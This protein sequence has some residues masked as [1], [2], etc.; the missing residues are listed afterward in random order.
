[1]SNL[2]TDVF[3]PIGII[4]KNPTMKKYAKNWISSTKIYLLVNDASK[5]I[6]KLYLFLNPPINQVIPCAKEEGISIIE[7]RDMTKGN[8]ILIT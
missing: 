3:L 7:L 1:M 8:N 6:E 5:Q 2:T 4:L